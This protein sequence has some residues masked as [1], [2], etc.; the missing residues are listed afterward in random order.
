MITKP[1]LAATLDDAD[2]LKY[3]VLATPKLDGI[4]CLVVGGRALSRAFKPIANAHVRARIER[5]CPSGFDGEIVAGATF[6][7]CQSLVMSKDGDPDFAYHVFDFVERTADS[8]DYRM[9]ALEQFAT[10][11]IV[12]KILPTLIANRENL[13]LYESQVLEQGH[14]GVML[15]TPDGP[16]KCGR[17]TV[18]EGYLLKL[19]R[20][21][22]AEGIVVG[23]EERMRNDNELTKDELGHAKRSSHQENQVPTGTLGAL[24]LRDA[25]SGVEF[26][27]GTGFDDALRR[28]IWDARD[29]H[30]GKLVTY[31][32]QAFGTKDRPRSPVFKGFRS[33]DDL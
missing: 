33:K 5:E 18:R 21:V 31:K 10:S 16:Y 24:L 19:K 25:K 14:E 7:D 22:D 26:G 4:R 13:D 23:F 32:Y 3:P 11:A 6:N 2:A 12:R 8:Y 29:E 28:K 27:V 20:F 15:R 30:L 17:S 9:R 1:M